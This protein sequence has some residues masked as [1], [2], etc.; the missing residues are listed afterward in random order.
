MFAFP[1]QITPGQM[2][3]MSKINAKTACAKKNTAQA[4]VGGFSHIHRQRVAPSLSCVPGP[5]IKGLNLRRRS[6][7]LVDLLGD[8]HDLA[9]LIEKIRLLHRRK[10]LRSRHPSTSRD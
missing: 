6:R 3:Y 5:L 1:A 9:L 8:D 7:E 4:R 10:S 2:I